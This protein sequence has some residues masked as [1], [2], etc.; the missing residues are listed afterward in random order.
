MAE[1]FSDIVRKSDIYRWLT[2]RITPKIYSYCFS[3]VVCLLYSWSSLNEKT[4]DMFI[5]LTIKQTNS[6]AINNSWEY[7]VRR[8]VQICIKNMY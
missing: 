2:S 4:V 8:G 5:I 1:A 6:H 3:P 7:D